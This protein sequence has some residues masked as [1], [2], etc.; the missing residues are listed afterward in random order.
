MRDE[1]NR[2]DCMPC[3]KWSSAKNKAVDEGMSSDRSFADH[4][5]QKFYAPYLVKL[6]VAVVVVRISLMPRYHAF[7]ESKPSSFLR[8]LRLSWE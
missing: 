4:I 7:I 3:A 8:S 1:D 5:V 2:I 6:P